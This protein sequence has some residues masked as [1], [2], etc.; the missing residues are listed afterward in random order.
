VRERIEYTKQ[1]GTIK[2][3]LPAEE[4]CHTWEDCAAWKNLSMHEFMVQ[5]GDAELAKYNIP[6]EKEIELLEQYDNSQPEVRQNDS[7]D[8]DDDGD[9]DMLDI[10]L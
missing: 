4:L 2:I 3:G 6:T 5:H 1:R 10:Y 7:Q 9:D 8:E